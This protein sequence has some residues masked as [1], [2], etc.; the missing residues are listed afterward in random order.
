MEKHLP[1]AAQKASDNDEDDEEQA[2]FRQVCGSY[3]QYATFHQTVWQGV[4]HRLHR[5]HSGSLLVEDG[6]THHNGTSG[7]AGPTVSSILPAQLTS[8][9]VENQTMSKEFCS[10]TIRNQFFLDSVLRYS[11]K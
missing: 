10:A 5:L 3:Q 2:H 8:G 7:Q 4:S 11:G 1:L 9:T 6:D